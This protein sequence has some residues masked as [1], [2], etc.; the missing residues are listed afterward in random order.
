MERYIN[1]LEDVVPIGALDMHKSL[2]P[3]YRKGWYAW[4]QLSARRDDCLINQYNETFLE[5]IVEVYKSV[6]AIL[7]RPA[8]GYTYEDF[9]SFIEG[10]YHGKGHNVIAKACS[11]GNKGQNPLAYSEVSARDPIFW[12]QAFFFTFQSYDLKDSH[13][14]KTAFGPL[15]LSISSI[16]LFF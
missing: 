12:R 10:K 2:G 1:G 14:N 16:F 5:H 4:K 3:G 8:H 11:V 15:F 6:E 7:N 13:E 9:A